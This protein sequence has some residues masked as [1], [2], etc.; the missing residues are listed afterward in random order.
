MHVGERFQLTLTCRVLETNAERIAPDER[1]L[2]PAA[3]SLTPYEVIEGARY[4][5]M[6]QG[7]WRFLQYRYTLRIIGEDLF[8][9]EIAVPTLELRYRAERAVGAGEQIGGQDKIYKLPAYPLHIESLVPKGASNIVDATDESFGDLRAR[10]FRGNA[11]FIAAGLV[12]V[13][14]PVLTFSVLL[15]NHRRRHTKVRREQTLDTAAILRRVN[16]ELAAVKRAREAS[17]WDEQLIGCALASFRIAA[18]VAVGKPIAQRPLEAG[19]SVLEG[20]VALRCR[21]LRPGRVAIASSF[22]PEALAGALASPGRH[23]AVEA[24]REWLSEGFQ[25][26]FATFNQARYVTE[27]V[28]PNDGALDEALTAG[29]DGVRI[30]RREHRWPRRVIRQAS[31]LARGWRSRWT[32]S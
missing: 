6:Y 32:H 25:Q 17:G 10:R 8:G 19:A 12:L 23:S 9:R 18:A 20:Q 26:A 4:P 30:L 31:R 11:A 1:L 15:R 16:R 29:S 27:D 24:R 5:D 21:S 2:E 28:P 3:V 14:P 7:R 22:T 13:L